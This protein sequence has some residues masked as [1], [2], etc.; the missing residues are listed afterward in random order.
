M[1]RM[2]HD[3]YTNVVNAKSVNWTFQNT[4]PFWNR[5]KTRGERWFWKWRKISTFCNTWTLSLNFGE[6]STDHGGFHENHWKSHDFQMHRSSRVFIRFQKG[7]VFWKVQSTDFAFTTFAWPSCNI[8]CLQHA[9]CEHVQ[10][11]KNLHVVYGSSWLRTRLWWT[12][13]MSYIWVFC[14]ISQRTT[15]PNLKFLAPVFLDDSPWK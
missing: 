11:I 10:I 13:R 15:P 5:T 12:L 1:H 8:R 2:W 4:Q 9:E 7:W 3:G 6:T 14:A